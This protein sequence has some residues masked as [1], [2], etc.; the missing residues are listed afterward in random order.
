MFTINNGEQLIYIMRITGV[1][2]GAQYNS[3]YS[4]KGAPSSAPMLL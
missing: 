4:K 1:K 3:Q 2:Q